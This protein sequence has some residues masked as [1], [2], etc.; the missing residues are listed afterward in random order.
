[1]AEGVTA[2]VVVQALELRVQLTVT[3]LLLTVAFMAKT[4]PMAV[5]KLGICAARV[6]VVLVVVEPAAGHLAKGRLL[7]KSVL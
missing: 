3:Q 6:K 1:M 5:A 2:V 4:L 7:A